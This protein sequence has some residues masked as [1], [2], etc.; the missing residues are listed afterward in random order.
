MP[1]YDSFL[2]R[3]K[4]DRHREDLL[5]DIDDESAAFDEEKNE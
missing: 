2:N 1:K 3:S 5:D 4:P